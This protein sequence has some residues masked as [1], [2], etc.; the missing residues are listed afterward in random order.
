MEGN[1]ISLRLL[2]IHCINAAG[3]QIGA[4][5][6]GNETYGSIVIS[7]GLTTISSRYTHTK[8]AA[9]WAVANALSSA[10]SVERHSEYI[11][12]P[13]LQ[14]GKNRVRKRIRV[15]RNNYE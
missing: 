3:P 11:H 14:P 1:K 9:T 12:T 15:R 13:W 4:T 7:A 2:A 6:V 10:V 8:Q 5:W